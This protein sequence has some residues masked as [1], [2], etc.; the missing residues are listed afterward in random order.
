MSHAQHHDRARSAI[1]LA[2]LNVPHGASVQDLTKITPTAH[3]VK[4]LAK[5]M[6]RNMKSQG[7]DG[8]LNVSRKLVA[9]MFGYRTYEEL[10]ADALPGKLLSH[11]D[12][13]LTP[14]ARAARAQQ[15]CSVL[16]S[17]GFSMEDA[18]EILR[19]CVVVAGGASI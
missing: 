1:G 3:V 14:P 4:R 6:H 9:R 19:T 12:Q 5:Q 10:Y 15:Y 17:L 13:D 2:L 7:Y 11:A 8:P 18:R 16:V